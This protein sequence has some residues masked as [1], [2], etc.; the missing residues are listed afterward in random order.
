MMGQ[1]KC[2][3]DGNLRVYRQAIAMIDDSAI[4]VPGHGGLTNRREL[5][6][7]LAMLEKA[8]AD[9]AAAIAAGQSRAQVIAASRWPATGRC[10]RAGP[11]MPMPSSARCMMRSR[12]GSVSDRFRVFHINANYALSL[13]TPAAIHGQRPS[14]A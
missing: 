10:N 13:R 9:V 8:R 7:Y 11:T 2:G 3:G 12:P 14:A 5:I 1:S 6:V 4:V